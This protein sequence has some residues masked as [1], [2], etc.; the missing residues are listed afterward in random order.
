MWKQEIGV[1]AAGNT[2]SYGLLAEIVERRTG[3][4]AE[5]EEWR[6][7]WRRDLEEGIQKYRLVFAR[8]GGFGG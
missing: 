7:R 5:K 1:Y 4:G 3:W 6:K 2:V 8:A